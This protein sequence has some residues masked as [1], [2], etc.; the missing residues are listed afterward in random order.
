MKIEGGDITNL[1]EWVEKLKK[2]SK[3]KTTSVATSHPASSAL[4]SLVNTPAGLDDME[5]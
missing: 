5:F 3:S 2:S 4:S 1:E